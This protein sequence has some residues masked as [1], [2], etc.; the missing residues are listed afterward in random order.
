[1]LPDFQ[2]IEHIIEFFYGYNSGKSHSRTLLPATVF[3]NIVGLLAF[4]IVVVRVLGASG[5]FATSLQAHK[6]DDIALAFP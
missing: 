2:L 4:A 6:H 5:G 3:L 1:M